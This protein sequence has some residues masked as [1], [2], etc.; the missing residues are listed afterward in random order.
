MGALFIIRRPS[1]GGLP[2]K[3]EILADLHYF[4]GVGGFYNFGG[5]AISGDEKGVF[6]RS[7]E[8]MSEER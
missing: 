6:S 8:R 3:L 5:V 4:S 1:T 7:E 2:I